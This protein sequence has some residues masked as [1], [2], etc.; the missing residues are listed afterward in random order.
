MQ[1]IPREAL[2]DHL[3]KAL[4]SHDVTVDVLADRTKVTRATINALL[5]EPASG[6]VPER[7]YLRGHL[8]VLASELNL[9][10]EHTL[11]LFDAAFPAEPTTQDL[12]GAPRFG[13]GS[14]AVAAGLATVALIAVALA[15]ANAL[16]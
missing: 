13:T 12:S 4:D 8:S 3:R 2:A 15:F 10:R 6:I 1:A 16:G 9:D 5:D 11:D 7:V 14:F